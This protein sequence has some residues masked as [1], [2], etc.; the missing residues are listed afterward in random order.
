M[1]EEDRIMILRWKTLI[2]QMLQYG[3]AFG[4]IM[5]KVILDEQIYD[6]VLECS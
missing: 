3:P 6:N 2:K 4:T 1:D 5:R